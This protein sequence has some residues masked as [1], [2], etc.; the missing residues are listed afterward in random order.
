[1]QIISIHAMHGDTWRLREHEFE[2]FA[3]LVGTR[4]IARRWPRAEPNA[5]FCL[6]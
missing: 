4:Q 1:M 2:F 6:T 3:F 5:C